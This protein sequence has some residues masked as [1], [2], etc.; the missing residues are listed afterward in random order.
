MLPVW[1]I[2]I[3]YPD[4]ILLTR[5]ASYPPHLQ[6]YSFCCG[7]HDLHGRSA[8]W[9]QHVKSMGMPRNVWTS[10]REQQYKGHCL[11]QLP[12]K[13]QHWHKRRICLCLWTVVRVMSV[14]S[15]IMFIAQLL[16]SLMNCTMYSHCE[17]IV[18]ERSHTHCQHL[19]LV[20]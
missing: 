7:M 9:W 19:G 10:F 5:C 18:L 12:G 8:H 15:G 1:I 3:Y 6:G 16:P 20:F 17:Y 14:I 13:H 11:H 2:Q 4:I